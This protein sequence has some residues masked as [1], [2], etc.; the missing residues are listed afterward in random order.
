M[1]GSV[2]EFKVMEPEQRKGAGA[3]DFAYWTYRIRVST[4]LSTYAQKELEV[5]RR[6]SDFEWFRAQLCEAY[7]YCI[8]PP[9]PEKD[10]QGTLDKFVGS[11]SQSANRLRDYRQRA[12]RKFLVRLGAHPR[13]H[14]SHLLKDFLE[15]NEEE[16]GRKM[17]ASGKN[18]D[19]FFSTALGGGASHA[20]TRQWNAGGPVAEAGSSYAR[21]LANSSTNLQVWEETGLYIH[22]LEDNIKML[23]DRLQ[24]LVDRRRKTGNALHEFGVAFEKVGEIERGIEVNPLSNAIIA[25]GQHSEQLFSIYNDHANEEMKQVVETLNYY[26]GMCAAVRETLKRVQ[27]GAR[28]VESLRQHVTDVAA[29]KERAVGKGGQTERVVKLENELAEFEERWSAAKREMEAGEA[30]FKDELRRFHQEKQYDMKAILKNF[31]ELQLKYSARMKET[32]ESLRP[33]VDA[34]QFEGNGGGQAT[35]LR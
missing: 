15:M 18:S 4:T 28:H 13:L 29:Q 9:I 35:T 20:L 23:R 27:S 33:T 11:D 32:W 22:H 17:K 34:V 3:L 31:A 24:T 5:V 25:A 14:T 30:I 6:Y 12:L 10:V 7:P 8:V 21:M 19:G 16:W 26:H 1:G 2:F